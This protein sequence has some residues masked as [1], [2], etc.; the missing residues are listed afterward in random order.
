MRDR[1]RDSI[2]QFRSKERDL[3]KRG[4]K[5]YTWLSQLSVEGQWPYYA[6]RYGRP[7]RLAEYQLRNGERRTVLNFTS[8]DYL[9]LSSHPWVIQA[10]V[11]ALT[12]FG[13]HSAASEP[14]GG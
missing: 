1:M 10:A 4:E 14:L 11:A 5:Y 8:Q 7:E 12:E 2:A 3:L 13:I 6:L 9:S